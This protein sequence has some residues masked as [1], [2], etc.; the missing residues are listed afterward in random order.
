MRY[1]EIVAGGDDQLIGLGGMYSGSH[2]DCTLNTIVEKRATPTMIVKDASNHFKIRVDNESKTVDTI[3][4]LG[5]RSNWRKQHL[6]ITTHIPA[7]I[8][9][10]FNG[11]LATNNAA[12]FVK[13]MA[14]L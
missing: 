10:G 12:G 3:D 5:G 1:L 4:A 8:S 9:Q 7:G 14:E 13:L 11:L 6:Q 2:F